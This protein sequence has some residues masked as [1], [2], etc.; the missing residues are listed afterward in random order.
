MDIEKQVMCRLPTDDTHTTFANIDVSMNLVKMMGTIEEMIEDMGY[1]ENSDPVELPNKTITTTIF[2]QVME[3]CQQYLNAENKE[4][5]GLNDWDT[6][7]FSQIEMKPDLFNLLE[8]ADF[9]HAKRLL[10]TGC[11]FVAQKI[12]G[13]SVE[14]LREIFGVVNDFTPDEE[15]QIKNEH[16]WA[17]EKSEAKSE[18]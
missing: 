18:E 1:D 12:K 14:D 17:E 5:M 3:Y 10:E 13:K 7:F 11:S 6:N 16:E 8:A 15:A 2:K 9:L 4:D